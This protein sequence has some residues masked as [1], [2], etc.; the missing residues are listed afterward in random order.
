MQ[1]RFTG[2]HKP[3][4]ICIGWYNKRNEEIPTVFIR[5]GL[6]SYLQR[7]VLVIVPLDDLSVGFGEL[8]NCGFEGLQALFFEL[9]VGLVRGVDVFI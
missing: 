8:G 9:V 4:H 6:Y 5:N 1:A 7:D 3:L 2:L